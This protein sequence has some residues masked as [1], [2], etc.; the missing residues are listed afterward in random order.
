MESTITIIVA[1]IAAAVP[2]ITTAICSY[3]QN[4]IT[5][6]HAAKQSILQLMMEDQMSYW[7]NGTLPVNFIAI[8]DEYDEYHKNG[9]N[10]YV[11]SK[12]QE[13]DDWIKSITNKRRKQDVES[14]KVFHRK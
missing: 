8:H 6:R 2:T 7:H 13:Y 1:L 11:T 12:V 5:K 3:L 10:H 9:G 4:R 14:K